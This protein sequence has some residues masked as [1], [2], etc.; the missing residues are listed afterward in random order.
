M[1]KTTK[2]IATTSKGT[3][4]LTNAPNSNSLRVMNR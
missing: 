2:S 1:N 4:R 3:S